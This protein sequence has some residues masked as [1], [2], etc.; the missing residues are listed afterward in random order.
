MKVTLVAGYAVVSILCLF[1]AA[2]SENYIGIIL[3]G[4]QKDCT[5]RSRGEDHE[6][7]EA[8]QLYVGDRIV[9]KPDIKA[10]K[11]RWAPYAS[12]KELDRTSLVVVFE[13]PK[14]KKGIVQEVKEVL[15][16]VKTG[17]TMSVGATRGGFRDVIPQPGNN[18]TLIMGEKATFAWE[19]DGGRHIV[20][21]DVKGREILRKELKGELSVQLSPEEIGIKAGDACLWHISGARNSRQSTVRVLA[22]DLAQQVIGDLN[23]IEAETTSEVERII[24][25][26]LYLQ[27]ISDA[28]PQDMD[29]YWLSY[30]IIEESDR[31]LKEDDQRLLDEMKRNYLRHVRE[32]T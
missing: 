12:G 7:M 20:F 21:R 32:A 27:F 3:D 1:S 6:C 13:P 9:K 10:L 23:H 4:Y 28:Y 22:Q 11:I 31:A 29:L 5:V 14:D 25:K 26:A 18:A 15:G 24:R 17:H 2:F 30:R 19:S 16:L 8:R